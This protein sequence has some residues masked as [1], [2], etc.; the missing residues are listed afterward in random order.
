MPPLRVPECV[1]L[2][3]RCMRVSLCVHSLCTFALPVPLCVRAR[4]PLFQLLRA[5]VQLL[6][7]LWVVQT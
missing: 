6:L 1:C 3:E 4:M 5:T 7:S 2:S